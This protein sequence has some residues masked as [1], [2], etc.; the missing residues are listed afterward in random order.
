ML[1]D[2]RWRRLDVSKA[3]ILISVVLA[4]LS[5]L[6]AIAPTQGS[7][8]L[9]NATI[10]PQ[11]QFNVTGC[12][13]LW[14]MHSLLNILT[15]NT[16]ELVHCGFTK[17]SSNQ[18]RKGKKG[19]T[20]LSLQVY[21][22]EPSRNF[23]R[24]KPARELEWKPPGGGL[25]LQFPNESNELTQASDITIEASEGTLM[26]SHALS[27]SCCAAISLESKIEE[28]IITVTEVNRGDICR[29]NC[30]YSINASLGPL[31]AGTYELRVYGIRT[32]NS[33]QNWSSKSGLLFEETV[34]MQ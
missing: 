16:T 34:E 12:D 15:W 29:C 22:T 27:Y 7:P 30:Q 8:I 6:G 24:N 20:D 11:L 17:A 19:Q 31:A 13:N 32:G 10:A 5:V 1:G 28:N 23:E 2:K 21:P 33:Y 3:Q 26:F 18:S 4:G 14:G 25:P 9:G